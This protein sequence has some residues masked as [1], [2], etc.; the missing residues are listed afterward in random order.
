MK[1]AVGQQTGK[2]WRITL[3]VIVG[4][5]L[6]AGIAYTWDVIANQGKVPRATSVGGVDI[7]SMER[8]A[9]VEKLE[10]ELG[11]V[12]TKPVNVTSGEKSSQLVP[13]ES[14]LT[15]NYQKAVDGIPDASYNPMTRLFSFVKA[16]KEIPVAVDIDDTALDGALERV[17]NE[18]S[19]APKDGMLELNNGQLKVTKPVLGQTVEPDDLKNSITENWLDPAGVEVEPV[20]VEPAINDDA[21]EAMRTGDVAKALDNPLTINGENNVAGTLR[22]DEIAQFVSIEAK[23]GKLELKVDTPKAQQLFEERMDGASVPGENAKIAFNG[24]RMVVTPSVDGSV[25]DWEKTLKDFDKRVKGDERTWDADYKPDPAEYTTE[26]AEKA[27]FNDTVSEFSTGGF[28]GASG[29]NIR[30]VAA[31]VDGAVVNPGETFSLNGYTGPRGTAQGYVESGIIINGH[32]GTA[33]GG[34]ISQFATT[35][36][37]AAYFAGFEDVAH[38]PHSYYISR[39]P[40]GR[41]ATVYEGSIDLQ[42]KNTTNTPVRIETSFGGGKITVRFK[43]VKTYNVE[44]VNNGRWATTQPTR[45]SVG[46]NCSPSSGAPGFTTSDTRIIKDLSGREISRETTTT[47]YDPQPIVS[48]G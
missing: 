33:V 35:L 2:G 47:V 27:T 20:E 48:C 25:I 24:G 5:L 43:G 22:K 11:D 45:M 40:A 12:E 8:T 36:Y 4:L 39:Y 37:N 15:L 6:I 29:E 14:G 42:F 13:A 31:Q 23:D 7:S 26:M 17:K 32:S 21:I 19:F 10:R 16:T 30:R 44:S 18:L 34:G 38:T 9:A 1:K 28:S 3:G 41:E 46:E